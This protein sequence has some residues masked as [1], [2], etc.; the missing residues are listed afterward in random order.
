MIRHYIPQTTFTSLIVQ[1][2]LSRIDNCN[3]VLIGLPKQQINCLQLVVNAAARLINGSSRYDHITP[4]L[5]DLHWL[6]VPERIEYKI[7]LL[8]YKCIHGLAPTYLSDGIKPVCSLQSRRRLRSSTSLDVLVPAT[9]TKMG[10]SAFSMWG[11]TTWNKLPI[12][13]CLSVTL[14]IFKT[15][16]N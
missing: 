1:L 2:I 6:R 10:N 8:V 5:S 16:L 9:K 7:C 3:I 12:S 13:M 11:S 15:R 4:L 14:A